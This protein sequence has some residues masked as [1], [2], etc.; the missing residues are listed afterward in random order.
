MSWRLYGEFIGFAILVVL[1]PGP[2]FAV[3]VKNALVGGRAR[4]RA[5]AYGI[6]LGNGLQGLASAAGLGAL[7]VH[8]RPAFETIRWC[9]V[10][11][12]LYLGLQALRRAAS[13]HVADAAS[14][15]ERAGAARGLRQGF[16]S[17]VT[18]P[19]VLAFY[20]AVLPQFVT[21][22][23]SIVQLFALALT[24]PLLGLGWLLAIVAAVDHAR[25]LLAR[26]RV[27]RS[28]DALTGTVLLAFAGKLAA[29][30]G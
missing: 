5:T 12:L 29:E 28:L 20:V 30:H 3:T 1:V 2:D 9:G 17:N 13:G 27:R 24:L 26:P 22:S 6:T 18:N 14:P 8:W 21:S 16:L 25:H 11:Y 7:I 10:A 15:A 19:K 23:T 4:G